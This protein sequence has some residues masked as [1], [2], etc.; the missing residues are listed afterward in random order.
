MIIVA[1][2]WHQSPA[3]E[4][5]EDN[6]FCSMNVHEPLSEISTFSQFL[7]G[8]FL[9]GRR[10]SWDDIFFYLLTGT[11]LYGIPGVSFICSGDYRAA[12]LRCYSNIRTICMWYNNNTLQV[13]PR[14]HLQA[15][16][17]SKEVDKYHILVS[18]VVVIWSLICVS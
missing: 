17:T 14:H 5:L 13:T 11:S 3:R 7:S 4:K 10:I 16:L 2:H 8:Q 12:S 15:L 6:D 1:A 18:L 9:S